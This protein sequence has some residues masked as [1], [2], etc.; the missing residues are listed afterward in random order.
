MGRSSSSR[1]I[2]AIGKGQGKQC[3]RTVSSATQQQLLITANSTGS[4]ISSNDSRGKHAL[5][6]C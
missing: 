5:R 6:H 4:S 3:C 1:W 2:L